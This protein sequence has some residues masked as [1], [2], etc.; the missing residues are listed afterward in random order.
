MIVHLEISAQLKRYAENLKPSYEVQDNTSLHQLLIRLSHDN[1]SAFQKFIL[2]EDESIRKS[3]LLGVNDK[4][5]AHGQDVV[6]K[7][8]DR[9]QIFTP[10]SGG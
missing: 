4:Q 2:E 9:V 5:V 6:L 1:G 8:R 10:I 3:L 7:D